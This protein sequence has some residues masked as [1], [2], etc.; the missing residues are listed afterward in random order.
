MVWGI[1]F[2]QLHGGIISFPTN[3]LYLTNSSPKPADQ[4]TNTNRIH[5]T[6]TPPIY[7]PNT[8]HP[9]SRIALYPNQPYH[10]TE[11]FT[12]PTRANTMMTI[13][14]ALSRSGNS[15]L[16]LPKQYF[17]EKPLDSTPVIINAENDN[18]PVHFINHS[19]HKVVI[20]KHS[21]AGAMEK[22]QKSNQDTLLTNNSS[23]PVSQHALSRC[24]AHSDVQPEITPLPQNN[25]T[26]T[27]PNSTPRHKNLFKKPLATDDT[28]LVDGILPFNSRNTTANC[29]EN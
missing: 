10:I 11:Q 6:Y 17:A 12:I 18:L 2:L 29:V 13:P 16:E 22:G 21:Y 25:S 27:S 9:S 23:E 1:D 3:Q 14:C 20:P 5:N 4:P 7:M 19:D 8:Y 26:E 28:V 15:L 24:L